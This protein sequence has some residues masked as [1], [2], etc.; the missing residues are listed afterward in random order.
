MQNAVRPR[1]RKE[2]SD[3]K[4]QMQESAKMVCWL[5]KEPKKK[6]CSL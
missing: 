6:S 1:A 2:F 4:I 3:A 5:F